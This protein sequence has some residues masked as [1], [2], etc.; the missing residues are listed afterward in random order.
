MSAYTKKSVKAAADFMGGPLPG[1]VK[2]VTAAYA[3]G[4]L[5]VARMVVPDTVDGWA[6]QVMDELETREK[7]ELL[8]YITPWS[9]S[10]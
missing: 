5:G 2:F 3:I 1:V 4:T 6:N 9:R 10:L 8:D 7:N